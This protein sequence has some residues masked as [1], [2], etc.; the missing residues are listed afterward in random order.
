MDRRGT[1]LGGR[2][3]LDAKIGTGGMSDVYAATDELLTRDVAVKMMR[4]DL[5]RDTTFLERFRREAQNA[6]KLN[7]P[8]IVAIYDTGETP[9]H[10]GS[11]PYIVME[12][13]HGE[14][15]RD[16]INDHGKMR[17]TDAARI[18]AQVA[19][20]LHF[21]HEAGIIHRDVK[22]ANI[23][24]TNTGQV[25]VMD[26]GIAR[27]LSDSSAAMTQTAA[28]I[29][30]AQYLS[31][32]QARGQSADSRSD[33]YALGCVFY[34]L[35]TGRP[36]F[37]GESPFSVAFQHVKDNPR[38]PSTVLGVH[39]S[40]REALS[41]DS[42]VLTAM[43]KAPEDR[44]D[45]AKQM[46]I[47][48][49]RLSEDQLPLV[50]Q[51]HTDDNTTTMFPAAEGAA[52]GATAATAATPTPEHPPADPSA[53]PGNSHAANSSHDYEDYEDEDYDDDYYDDDYYDSPRKPWVPIL[54]TLVIIVLLGGG[55]WVAYNVLNDSSRSSQET[56]V[57]V[58]NVENKNRQDAEDALRQAGLEFDV[59]ERAHESIER[60]RAIATEPAVGS[61]VPS[62]SRVTLV[63]S[64][65][66][67]ITDVPDL[68]NLTTED[69]RK[70]LEKAGLVLNPEVKEDSSDDAPKGTVIGQSP[71]QGSQVSKGTKVTITVS[72]GPENVR[73]PVVT[74][75]DEQT[76][77]SNLES[78]GFTVL[79]EPVDSPEPE[80]TVVKVSNEGEQL[81]KGSQVTVSVSKGNQF[82]MPSLQGKPYDS[83]LRLLQEAGWRGA[84]DLVQ[85]RDVTTPD[86]AR[87]NE[88]AQQSVHA[89]DPVARDARIILDVYTFSLLPPPPRL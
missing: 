65:G 69:A 74:G 5:A 84:P 58:P 30:T 68:M 67:E 57:T 22:P 64:S 86:L 88:I 60:G 47:D 38:P 3:R 81:P 78:A 42:I 11:V 2:Y 13:V 9:E 35:A 46:S 27:A 71:A 41:L 73:V 32:E 20:A 6:A 39:L 14:T 55:G 70:A 33:I 10:E 82:V 75:Q 44:Y 76:A 19:D 49:Q 24:I 56:R 79:V 45:D 52:A 4:P 85:R 15:L 18:M 83:A 8:N 43:A 34:E 31:P 36:P 17:L 40:K 54:W 66:K 7:H 80:N 25:K 50:A 23:M 61:S 12:R 77:R 37:E 26:F 21:S 1:I 53:Y 89:G 63:I 59:T 28:V 87:N 62:G 16:I 72:S 51:T 29:G 48:L